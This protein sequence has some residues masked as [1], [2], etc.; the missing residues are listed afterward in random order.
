MSRDGSIGPIWR[1]REGLARVFAFACSWGQ[2]TRW[3][4]GVSLAG[5]SHAATLR[6]ALWLQVGLV[7]SIAGCL[8]ALAATRHVVLL[9]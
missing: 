8:P 4:T 7:M 3:A 9:L 6:A 2:L 5:K 1:A